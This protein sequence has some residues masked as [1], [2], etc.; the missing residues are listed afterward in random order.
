MTISD[1]ATRF[2]GS[3]A[4]LIGKI[5]SFGELLASTT[6]ESEAQG[7]L[8]EPALAALRESGAMHMRVPETLGGLDLPIADQMAVLARLAEYDSAS[9]WCTMVANNGIG[10][11]A[12]FISDAG[13]AEIFA[14]DTPPIG[15]AVAAATG[16][17]VTVE[18]GYRVTGRWR[19][20]S[21]V[22]AADWVRCTATTDTSPSEDLMVVVPRRD[23]R[24]HPTWNVVGLRGSGSADFE[25]VDVFVPT[26]R[27]A[28]DR[29]RRQLRGRH[30]YTRDIGGVFAVYE[31]AAIAIG[32]ARRA[33]RLLA[34]L[35]AESPARRERES[36]QIEFSRL[37]LELEAAEVLAFS[38]FARAD[39][40]SVTDEELTTAG[41]PAIAT[42]VTEV[43]QRCA[44]FAVKRAGSQALF[45]PNGFETVARDITA[46]QVHVLVSDLNYAQH[47]EHLLQAQDR[48]SLVTA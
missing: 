39:D 19:F 27:T 35:L 9:A 2:A 15:A 44:A 8:A 6:L 21:N 38:A 1:N 23:I 29:E 34:R 5:D 3:A 40:D 37:T 47:G 18:G 14:G 31:H 42:Y 41:L 10:G 11:M 28:P 48:A 24:I 36:V 12:Q 25:L 33:M 17:A 7:R 16:V 45:L 22:H 46:A 20:C 30:N 26:S 4:E 13:V 32:L 43:A